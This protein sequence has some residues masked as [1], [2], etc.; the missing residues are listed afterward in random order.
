MQPFQHVINLGRQQTARILDLPAVVG[1]GVVWAF[2]LVM[3]SMS[4][5]GVAEAAPDHS[6]RDLPVEKLD[7]DKVRSDGVYYG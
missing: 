2:V 4:V 5:V 1:R 7:W 6:W 3:L